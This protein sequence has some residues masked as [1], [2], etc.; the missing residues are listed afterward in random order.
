M[1]YKI[2]DVSQ[3]QGKIDWAKLKPHIDGV[4]IRVGYGDDIKSQDDLYAEY[5][6][7][8]CERL[9]IPYAV[10]I[11]SYASNKK[12]N[13]S[14]I[15]HTKRVVANY[16]PLSF[17]LDLEEW[18]IRAN[19]KDAANAWNNAFEN[20]GVYAG[21]A[22]WKDPLKDVQ[23]DIWC[24]A[25]GTNSGKPEKKF[26]PAL[27]MVGWQ[28][29]SRATFPGIN[30]FVDVSEWY[31]PFGK[32]KPKDKPAVGNRTITKKMV[33]VEIMKHLCTHNAHGYTQDMKGRQGTGTEVIYIYGKKYVIPGGDRDC[34]SAV[35]SS[36][37]AAGISCGGASYTGNMKDRMVSTGNFK[38]HNMSFIAQSGDT[39]LNEECHT[40]MCL[41]AEPDV[42]MEFSIN[43]K[44]TTT[45]GK[46]GDQKQAG[47]YDSTYGRGESHLALYYDYGKKG[48]DGILECVNNEVAFVID[49]DGNIIEDNTGNTTEVEKVIPDVVDISKA[50]A[51]KAHLTDISDNDLAIEVLFGTHGSGE[52]RKKN[53]G[54]R[55][56]TVQEDVNFYLS[57]MNNFISDTKSYI[58]KYGSDTL[59]KK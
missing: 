21:Q 47:E 34:S 51:A 17:W 10:Y 45:G 22:W 54:I 9:G 13:Q 5:N 27:D 31:V 12:Q 48:W 14:E 6:L 53:L 8:E 15:N 40:A 58:K 20:S 46:I 11:Y 49:G 52:E 44:G 24:P 4:I 28:Y 7:S 18:N 36:Y 35:I 42:L 59:V 55:Y 41:S 19:G 23:S 29:T 39:Y 43:E 3:H 57:H 32:E 37:E 30:G 56:S 33:A 25:Y 16:N 50:S 2:I 38:W 26:K 1:A